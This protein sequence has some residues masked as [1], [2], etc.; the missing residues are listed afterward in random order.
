GGYYYSYAVAQMPT[1]VSFTQ[2]A[3]LSAA[4]VIYAQKVDYPYSAAFYV[5][6]ATSISLI[7]GAPFPGTTTTT[8]YLIHDAD[9]VQPG[10]NIP[11]DDR[12]SSA[13]GRQS[14]GVRY[15]SLYTGQGLVNYGSNIIL[16]PGTGNSPVKVQQCGLCTQSAHCTACWLNLPTDTL[17][18]LA[19]VTPSSSSGKIPQAALVPIPLF[20]A[21]PATDVDI[22]TWLRWGFSTAPQVYAASAWG[23]F[24][25]LT[26]TY[27]VNVTVYEYPGPVR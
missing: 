15:L 26:T 17:L 14:L 8:L 23:V 9:Y 24:N 21:P 6:N 16:D 3:G 27:L 10:T 7:Y 25:S 13:Q 2:I 1:Y 12:L 20:P 19:Y 22:K 18:A 5:F 4:L 11:C